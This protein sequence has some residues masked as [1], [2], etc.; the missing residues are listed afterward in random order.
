MIQEIIASIIA[1]II[2]A[3]LVGI[4]RYRRSRVDHVWNQLKGYA[5]TL[6]WQMENH[7]EYS[8]TSGNVFL[9]ITTE[10]DVV[11]HYVSLTAVQFIFEPRDTLPS[12]LPH[13]NVENYLTEWVTV[14]D[15][16]QCL[17]LGEFGTGKS[18]LV[19]RVAFDLAKKFLEKKSSVLPVVIPMRY[20]YGL[21][22]LNESARLLTERYNVTLCTRQYLVEAVRSGKV[23]LILDGLDEFLRTH[24]NRFPAHEF[25]M[26]QELITTKAK[27]IITSRPSIFRTPEELIEYFQTGRQDASLI[28]SRIF[29]ANPMTV[30]EL[31]PFS[32]E[33]IDEVLTRRGEMKQDVRKSIRENQSIH[34]L[35]RQPI[36]LNMIIETLPLIIENRGSGFLRE[37]DTVKLYELYTSQVIRRDLWLVSMSES[38]AMKICEKIAL[39]MFNKREEE[40][41]E[42]AIS[43]IALEVFEANRRFSV[44]VAPVTIHIRSSLFMTS[45]RER[46]YRFMH[47]TVMEFFVAKGLVNAIRERDF[48]G[49]NLERIVY[50]E[51]TSH[52]ARALLTE[53]DLPTLTDLLGHEE[54]WARFIAA[55][56]LSRLNSQLAVKLIQTHLN[57][58]KEFIVRREF[59]IALAFLGEVEQFHEFISELDEND[60]KD[61]ENDKLVVDYF[62]GV[63]AALDGCSQR[64]NERRD[65]PTREM[66]IRFLGHK[67]SRKHIPI[68]RPYLNDNI[69]TVKQSTVRAI[70]MIK[71]RNKKPELVRALLL[72]VDGVVVDSI[73]DHIHTW[74]KAFKETVGVEFDPQI[75]RLTE[76][77]KSADVARQ[78]LKY[79]EKL[80]S[81]EEIN[82]IVRQKHRFMKNIELIRINPHTKE[83]MQ[84]AKSMGIKT[85]LVTASNKLRVESIANLVGLDLIDTI[86]SAEDTTIGKPA[87]DPYILGLE[88]IYCTPSEAI[89]VEN[90][91]RGIDSVQAAEIYCV[92]LTSTLNSEFLSCADKVLADPLEI[93]S[94]L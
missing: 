16:A 75:I 39:E 85:V 87:P 61:R 81:E 84:I 34:Q 49:L 42:S 15:Q 24:E 57:T 71:D 35:A 9:P 68:L 44:D 93:S 46:K 18:A 26:L 67:G 83:L 47:L 52:F 38:E 23:V 25:K 43:R 56:Y 4:S 65:Y 64:L 77:M 36:L 92:A 10:F 59:Y 72:D 66:I 73:D 58:E 6:V 88:K 45:T 62:T 13:S 70:R 1:S 50:H 12:L 94:L 5:H 22:I 33:Q 91:P 29:S 37:M 60:E 7:K 2:F 86:V 8:E 19:A 20:L 14:S 41:E 17:I 79:N 54:L 32:D 90:A 53:A 55:H 28:A 80:V 48:S 3:L 51:A 74:Q 30:L 31:K 27:V 69:H 76:G 89:A 21:D 82:E 63:A 78:I 11:N 40:V